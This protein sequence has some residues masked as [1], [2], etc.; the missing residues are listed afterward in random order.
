MD[1][2]QTNYLKYAGFWIRVWATIIDSILLAI[3]IGP[4]LITVYGREYF[5]SEKFMAGP[6]DFLISWVLPVVAIIAFWVYKSATP[7]KMAISAKIVDA[8]TGSKP[9]NGQFVG[10]YFAYFVST[11]PLCLGFLWVAFDS[12]KQGWHDKLAGTV[13]VRQVG[14]G[15]GNVSFEQPT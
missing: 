10:R 7:G 5:V 8:R 14:V 2:E 1:T 13:V 15:S 12:M 4:L 6:M 11:I 9:S 3:I